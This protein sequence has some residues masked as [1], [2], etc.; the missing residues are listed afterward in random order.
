MNSVFVDIFAQTRTRARSNGTFSLKGRVLSLVFTCHTVIRSP[1]NTFIP[2]E[3]FSGFRFFVPSQ[4]LSSAVK[5]Y[6]CCTSSRCGNI[7]F[8]YI[9]VFPAWAI[10][11]EFSDEN[12]FT[13]H[14][15]SFNARQQSVNHNLRRGVKLTLEHIAFVATA[16]KANKLRDYL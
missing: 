10:E 1:S 7:I 15:N 4:L 2:Q 8:V 16:D 5:P 6:I 14:I 11:V 12:C 3:V 13:T 9:L